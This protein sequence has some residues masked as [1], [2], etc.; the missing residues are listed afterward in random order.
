M[1]GRGGGN[2]YVPMLV[3]VG[4]P[5]HEAATTGQLILVFTSVTAMLVFHK[6]GHVDW[7]LALIIEPPTTLMAL[8]GGYFSHCVSGTSLK[9]ILTGLLVLA[10]FCM[11][12][13]VS[14]RPLSP[15]KH[16]GFWHREFAS[17]AYVVNLWL[18]IPITAVVG[19]AAGAVGISGGSFKVPLMVLACGVPMRI[20]VGTSSAMVAATALMGF[21]G[22]TAGGDFNMGYALPAA[23]AGAVG[24]LIGGKLAMKTKSR[25]L[26]KW[27]AYTT[28]VAAVFMGGNALLTQ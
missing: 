5:M 7:K 17:N 12:L 18:V 6:Y 20:A 1:T 10:G 3:A 8:V 15:K 26:K 14:E 27:F 28:L 4:T 24:G 13:K 2:F 23:C 21:L 11:L 22:H 19:L 16:V 25:N 9:L